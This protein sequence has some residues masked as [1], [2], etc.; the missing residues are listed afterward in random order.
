MSPCLKKSQLCSFAALLSAAIFFIL[1]F[2]SPSAAG[3][4]LPYGY[5]YDIG[6][7][8]AN[9]TMANTD[10]DLMCWAA[11]ASNILAWGGWGTSTY[12]TEDAIWQYYQDHWTDQGGLMGY[13][14]DWWFDGTNPTQGLNTAEDDKTG[15]SQVD[16]PGGGFFPTLDFNDYYHNESSDD[17]AMSAIDGYLHDGYGVTIGI[18]G[19]GGHAL[20][21]WGYDY[22]DDTGDYTGLL[23][24][25]SDDYA[26]VDGSTKNLWITSLSY[27]GDKWYL[28]GSNWYIGEVQALESRS[29]PEPSTM[30]LLASG[31]V[32][33]VGFGR[34]FRKRK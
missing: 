34:K 4:F 19:P 22:D 3:R 20:T 7:F 32:G 5:T 30:L 11:A 12:S 23:Y 15:W 33:F 29:V 6:W 27:S 31:L 10:D 21:V 8:D 18:Y 25:D 14:W 24:S 16:V 9:K 1:V 13:G 17:L 2:A 26:S 28:G